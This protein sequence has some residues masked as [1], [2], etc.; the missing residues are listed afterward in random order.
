MVR[1]L[2]CARFEICST[3]TSFYEK[4]GPGLGEYFLNSLYSDI[5]LLVNFAGIHPIVYGSHRAV[6][7]RFPYVIYYRIDGEYIDVRAVFESRRRPESHQRR[8]TR[9]R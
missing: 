8:L 7:R 3:G 4:Q 6:S 2:D 9:R 1:I 5:D